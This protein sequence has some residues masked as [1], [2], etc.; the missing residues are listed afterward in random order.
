[1]SKFTKKPAIILG[2]VATLAIA[3]GAYAYFTAGG[4]GTGTASAQNAQTPL[5]VKQTSSPTA[6]FPGDSA[7]T[8]SGNFNNPNSGP[9]YVGTVTAAIASVKT[10][11]G[12]PVVGCDASDFT[13]TNAAMTVNAEVAAGT[14]NG[15][16]TGA[17]IQFN[18][19][20]S[21]QDACKGVTV[22]L[23]YTIS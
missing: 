9:I 17:K 14:A 6:M 10:A 3:T 16:W 15:A 2:L 18:N 11:G 13:L 23:A 21:N 1:M 5:V 19:K 12:D 22:N 8:L 20:N 7:Q 4:S